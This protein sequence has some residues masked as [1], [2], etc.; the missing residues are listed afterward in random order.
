MSLSTATTSTVTISSIAAAV[1]ITGLTLVAAG[2]TGHQPAHAGPPKIVATV[3]MDAAD[4]SAAEDATTPVEVLGTAESTADQ[5]PKDQTPGGM[6]GYSSGR[7]APAPGGYG[8]TRSAPTM[9]SV[10]GGYGGMSG[11]GM[12]AAPAPGDYMGGGMDATPTPNHE[13]FSGFNEIPEEYGVV[14]L[15]QRGTAET[16]IM[17]VLKSPTQLDFIEAPLRDVVEFLKEY[18]DIEIQIDGRS[19]EDVGLTP[20]EPITKSLR[21][22]SLRSALRLILRDRHLTYV[23]RDEVLH[24]TTLDEAANITDTRV[25]SMHRL[26]GFEFEGLV[27]VITAT[28]R[29][30]TWDEDGGPG[31]IQVLPACLVIRQTQQVHEEIADLLSQLEQH[32]VQMMEMRNE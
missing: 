22:I 5:Q 1:V 15:K 28:V 19:L 16:R 4:A 8:G 6:G 26:Q 11:G 7:A 14:D 10:G 29:P 12:G 3:S 2:T 13:E 25:Y 21:G 9:G 18:H 23:I 32:R 20:D 24:I 31:S 27:E 30:E 17:E